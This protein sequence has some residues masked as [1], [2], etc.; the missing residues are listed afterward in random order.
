MRHT[1]EGGLPDPDTIPGVAGE[2]QGRAAGLHARDEARC[3]T[4]N[5]HSPKEMESDA[6]PKIAT[7]PTRWEPGAH[8]RPKIATAPTRAAAPRR[9]V[10]PRLVTHCGPSPMR[11]ISNLVGGR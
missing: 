3:D 4:Q 9:D 2:V 1:D 7:A 8:R 5:R 11:E 10:S 6:I